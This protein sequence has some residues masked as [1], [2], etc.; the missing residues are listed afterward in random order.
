MRA[1]CGAHQQRDHQRRLKEIKFII[2]DGSGT[3]VRELTG[4]DTRDRNKAGLNLLKWDLRV[5]PLLP[6][7]PAPGAGGGGGGFGG[8]G[9]NN[10]PYVL[11]GTYQATLNV[12]GRDAQTIDVSVKGDPQ[13][14]ITDADRKIWHDTAKD[15]HD[16]QAKANE[17]AEMVQN[18]FAQVGVL[19]QQ[20]RGATL[21]PSVKQQLDEVVKEFEAVRRRLGLGQQGG[22]GGFG[23]NPEN[24]RG[25][26]GQLKGGV[27]SATTLPTNTQLMQIR[28]TKAQVPG[29]IDQ[30]NA[31]VAKVPG[32]V[33]DMVGAGALFPAIKPV[34]KS[35]G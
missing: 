1:E 16:L 17:V 3:V 12:N 2:K 34:P 8:G 21:S 6:L 15:L 32:L 10:G 19:Q 23:G 35:A 31:A 13:I 22:G 24:V 28:E 29:L 9:G 4:T 11:P 26:I 27:M 7:P 14:Q 20:T 18:A 30:A 5:Q 25:R 33:K